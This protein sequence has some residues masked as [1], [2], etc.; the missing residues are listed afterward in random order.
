[1]TVLASSRGEVA[2]PRLEASPLYIRNGISTA[3]SAMAWRFSFRALGQSHSGK[4]RTRRLALAPFVR[5]L[6][7]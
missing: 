6:R 4:V 7:F 1:V 3:W 5:P 2:L